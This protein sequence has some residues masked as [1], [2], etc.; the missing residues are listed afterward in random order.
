MKKVFSIGVAILFSAISGIS[1]AGEISILM[2]KLVEKG[3]LSPLEAQI[4]ADETKT[5]VSKELS[6]GKSYAAPSWVQK[7]KIK[8]DVRVRYQHEEETGKEYTR[9]RARVRYRLGITADP[10]S[11]VEVGAG[12][13]TGG[14]D[15]RSTNQTLENSFQTPDIR[16]DYAYAK[17]KVAKDLS[18]Y[19]GKFARKPVLWQ[20]TDL[21]WDGDVNP[22]G[23]AL[24]FE[25]SLGSST[26][27][28]INAG[29]FVLD[30]RKE[31]ADSTTADD[32]LMFF[33]QPGLS[34]SLTDNVSLKTAVALYE[35]KGVQGNTLDHTSGTNS[36]DGGLKYDYNVINPSVELG[37]NLE[38][39]PVKYIGV[40]GD[41]VKNP[42]P[43]EDNTGYAVGFKFGHKKVKKPGNWQFK[44]INRKIEKDAW[45]DNLPDSDAYSGKTGV[46]G[47]EFIFEYAIKENVI[48][49]LDYYEMEKIADSDSKQQ[50]LQ[51]D[52][53]V[54]F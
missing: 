39:G 45:L 34:I 10:V 2:D 32:P 33:V 14:D 27:L 44:Y 35:M 24:A 13:A 38:S 6:E 41:Y 25:H 18:L 9:D 12:L 3:V 37:V 26:D 4:I 40:F 7:M 30:E 53:V 28:F 49:G 20:T 42:D 43:D 31:E 22:E 17:L 5:A 29:C 48:L 36:T 1:Y 47:N 51:A 19:A 16:L 23:G 50:V 8:G 54:K 21:M 15:P 52:L 46:K 11:G